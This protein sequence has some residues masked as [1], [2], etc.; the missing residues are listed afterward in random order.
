MTASAPAWRSIAR[1]A[2]TVLVGQFAVIGFGVADTVMTGRH[3]STDLAALSV[4]AAIYISVYIGLMGI[5]QALIPIAGRL[6]GAGKEARIGPLVRQAV[7]LALLLAVPGALLMLYPHPLLRLTGAP[8]EVVDRVSGYLAWLALGLPLALLFRIY[9]SLSQAISRPL[10]VTG[11]QLGALALKVP[12]NAWLI[13]GGA[14]VPALGV[15][16][17]AIATVLIHLVLVATAALLLRHHPVYRPMGLWARMEAPSWSAQREL[18]RLGLP[19]GLSYFV[20]V[21]AF[22]VMSLML[23]RLGTLTLAGHQIMANLTGVIYMMPLS[24]AV[25]TTAHV[26]Q[27]LGA[28]RP[29]AA[30]AAA[31]QGMALATAVAVT[32][33]LCVYLGRETVVGI[34]TR[35]AEVA[36]LALSLIA[37]VAAFQFFDAIQVTAA[38]ALRAYHVATWPAVVYVLGLWG[39]GLGGGYWAA[40]EATTVLPLQW[41]GPRGLW[42]ANALGLALVAAA[43]LIMLRRVSRMASEAQPEGSRA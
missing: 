42:A 24:I 12:L 41:Q 33:G 1:H 28:G 27:Q 18:L 14:G 11:L 15:L 3:A 17:C 23:A 40:F 21:T 6:H 22:A 34:Y 19:M 43:L 32:A 13:F 35:D 38:F 5:V 8:V 2:G 26:A 16:G 37:I 31:W 20:E 7:W 9:S 29:E 25:A 39:V 36:A 10:L 30:R 4:G